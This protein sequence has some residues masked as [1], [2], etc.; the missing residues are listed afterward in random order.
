MTPTAH[1]REK[2]VSACT[3]AHRAVAYSIL[4]DQNGAELELQNW[5]LKDNGLIYLKFG[6]KII[7]KLAF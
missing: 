7:F 4:T 6:G 2:S 1:S 3:R 5:K